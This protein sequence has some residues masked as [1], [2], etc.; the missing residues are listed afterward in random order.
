MNKALERAA[1]K[2]ARTKAL[3][4]ALE[5]IAR[6]IEIDASDME[7]A[8]N[9]TNILYMAQELVEDAAKDLDDLRG[10][11]RILDVMAAA[12]TLHRHLDN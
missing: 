8:E 5:L 9:A 11:I 12:K 4:C 3:L 10:D 7:A 1:E 6:D 2:T